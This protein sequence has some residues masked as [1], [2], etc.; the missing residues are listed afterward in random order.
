M[1]T[2]SRGKAKLI[3]KP[4]AGG[5][6]LGALGPGEANLIKAQTLQL[7]SHQHGGAAA[8]HT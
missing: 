7:Q 2:R 3:L 1:A 6:K 5:G 4:K 8:A